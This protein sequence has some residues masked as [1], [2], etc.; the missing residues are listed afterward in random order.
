M[1]EVYCLSSF[2]YFCDKILWQKQHARTGF[3]LLTGQGTVQGREVNAAGTRGSSHI[4]SSEEKQRAKHGHTPLPSL[5]R[6]SRL[7]SEDHFRQY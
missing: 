7:Q 1:L 4:A 3:F 2:V 5:L 6:Q